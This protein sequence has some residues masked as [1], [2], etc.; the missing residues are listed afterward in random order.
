MARR[1]PRPRPR[2]G[3]RRRRSR[4]TPTRC[5]ASSWRSWPEWS[6]STS[7]GPP[8]SRV[9]GRTYRSSRSA[10]GAWANRALDGW[11]PLLE[12][13]VQRD[14]RPR[15]VAPGVGRRGGPDGLQALLGQFASTMGPIMLGLQFGSAAGHL[16][17]QALGQYPLVVPWPKC[18]ELLVVPENV[19]GVRRGLEPAEDATL[20]WVCAHELTV[21]LVLD[22]PHI[23]ARP[24][25]APRGRG[26][27]VD[28]GP[29]GHRRP[30]VRAPAAPSRCS[31]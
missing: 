29:A 13:M 6:S 19:A 10:R 21:Q 30:A 4:G 28:G 3:H 22:R 23:A 5:S 11:R 25:R 27:R 16:A 31:S 14:R 15:A 20:L 1:R 12:Q 9:G 26:R 2:R 17:R 7:R 18:D 24:Q 8:G